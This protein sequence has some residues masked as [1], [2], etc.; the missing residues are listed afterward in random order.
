[1][2]LAAG[3]RL[4]S[5][6]ILSALG[7]GG[8]GEVYR[9]RDTKLDRE[10]AIKV[11]PAE[12][13]RDSD[14]L[15]RFE[16][17]ARAAAALNHPNIVTIFSV[18]EA[19]GMRF[20]TMEL[21]DGKSLAGLIPKRGMELDRLLG[22]AIPLT[23]AISAAHHAG[24]T[25]RDLKPANV[26]IASD[27]RVKVL[28]FGL[29]KRTPVSPL[30]VARLSAVPTMTEIAEGR[31]VGT[32]AYMSPE[33]AQGTA[34]DQR[35][36]I[37]SLG[38]ILY[39]MATGERP[40]TGSTSISILSSIVK[41]TPR[42]ATEVKPDL[43]REL[44]RIIRR[45]LMKDP[46]YRFQTAKDLR[47][48][49]IELK[50]ERD[51]AVSQIAVNG[52]A[53]RAGV[54]RAAREQALRIVAV[55]AIGVLVVAVLVARMWFGRGSP[56]SGAIDSLAVLPFVNVGGDPNTEY[57]SD[58]ITENLINGFSQLPKLRVVP[59]ARVFHY[60]GR[61]SEPE[62][63][64]RELNV[65]AVLT[66]R[67]VQHGDD[68]IIQVDLVDVPNDS[69]LWGRQ[70][71]TRFSE[72]ITLQDQI[73]TAVAEKLGLSPTREE[74]KR[75][76]KRYTKNAEAHQLY[77]RGRYLWNRRTADT[78]R[79]AAQYFQ[80]AIE[81]DPGYALAWAGLADCYGVYAI[82]SIQSNKDSI[83]RAKEAAAKALELD[84]TLAEAHASLGY[85]EGYEWDWSGA[86]R[87]FQRAIALDP[88]YPTAHHWRATNYLEPMGRLEEAYAE[89]ERAQELDP[90][91]LVISATM[92]RNL[93]FARH[94]DR[95][96]QQLS[97]TL[98]INS[99]FA[100][101]HWNVGLIDEQTG[102]I[103]HAIAEF[104]EWQRL[105]GDDPAATGALGHAYAVSGRRSEARR[106]LARLQELSQTR[107]VA[108][109]DVAVVYIGLG[110]IDSAMEWL[111]KAYDDHSAW[112][113]WLKLDRRFE[114]IRNDARYRELLHGMNIPEWVSRR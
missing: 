25:H 1:M 74:Q 50:Q 45:C 48:D 95:A 91:S 14:R 57:L 72:I 4:G 44:S 80:Q 101:A 26:M 103:E 84:E 16:H 99:S 7:S 92:A 70:Y 28:D 17:E 13:S 42:L 79:H 10:V 102:N 2:A 104:K 18:E 3:A 22:I 29:A 75:L 76:T 19:D 90:L 63:V 100:L 97:K 46:E 68:L 39:E 6:E 52:R 43:P 38:I 81:R 37:F 56:A 89:F 85:A 55:R 34:V 67:I 12:F 36:D 71:T 51:S 96:A 41:D 62:K 27:G 73:A 107:Y 58:G 59:R 114:S 11:L 5:Y 98:E 113:I 20:L 23:D 31:I 88:S 35:S 110:D 77:L 53:P 87:E 15:R 105:S 93:M 109:Y 86:E 108:P 64:G 82:Y 40:F 8:M 32:V 112:L 49:L 60:K 21:V 66:G 78:V 24:I 94:Y 30:D 33:Q 65:L 111:R 106:S 69:Q 61:E 9:A 54:G 47:N 83:P